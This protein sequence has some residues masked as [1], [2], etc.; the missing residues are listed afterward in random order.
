MA[1]SAQKEKNKRKAPFWPAC[2]GEWGRCACDTL[3]RWPLKMHERGGRSFQAAHTDK[4]NRGGMAGGGRG[5]ESR[6]KK[7]ERKRRNEEKDER[8]SERRRTSA[9]ADDEDEEGRKGEEEKKEEG[10]R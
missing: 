8:C 7:K 6:E 9:A 3:H 4:G 2:D 1:G 10:N 5:E